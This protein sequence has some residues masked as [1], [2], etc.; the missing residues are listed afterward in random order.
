MIRLLASA[1][2][3]NEDKPVLQSGGRGME[4]TG[5]QL[6]REIGRSFGFWKRF[7]AD[8]GH[9]I[10]ILAE[11]SADWLIQFFGIIASGNLAVA[12]GVND[13]DDEIRRRIRCSDTEVMLCDDGMISEYEAEQSGILFLEMSRAYAKEA[14]DFAV[15]GEEEEVMLLFSSGTGGRSKIVPLTNGNLLAFASCLRGS[16]GSHEETE[17]GKSEDAVLIPVPLYHISGIFNSYYELLKGNTLIISSPKYLCRDIV[18]SS[19]TKAVLVPSMLKLLA[20]REV[21]DAALGR[22]VKQIRE[23]ICLGAALP[24]GLA[25][26]LKNL[27]ICITIYYGLTETAGI[28]S[29]LGDYR[30]GASG[31]IVPY[32]DVRFQDGEILLKGPNVMHGYYKNPEETTGVL[33][34]GWLHTGDLAEIRDGWLYIRGRKKNIII[35][36]NGENVSPEELEEKLYACPFVTECLVSEKE[37]QITAEIYS[38]G[39]D[40]DYEERKRRIDHYVKQMNQKLP[41]THRITRVQIRQ[42]ELEKT[43]TGKIKRQG[44]E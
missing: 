36:D 43:A 17:S 31:K 40:M 15:R 13:S 34:N 41:T 35:L 6:L 29:G 44:K 22:Q 32:M 4:L 26:F 18:S 9:H 30:D 5:K 21:K 7:F 33:K 23:V 38:A 11:N 8:S 19:V 2:K 10:G 24:F 12:Y 39:K 3:K 37:G 20:E 1:L 28:V 25:E 27:G 16:S 14:E 42:K